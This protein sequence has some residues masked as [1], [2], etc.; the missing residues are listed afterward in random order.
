[1][2]KALSIILALIMALTMALPAFAA[3]AQTE[4][5]DKIKNFRFSDVSISYNLFDLFGMFFLDGV[6]EAF[7][8][9]PKNSKGNIHIDFV[10]EDSSPLSDVKATSDN[11]DIIKIEGYNENDNTI[12]FSTH[13][14]SG[15]AVVTVT[16]DGITKSIKLRVCN[17]FEQSII[18]FIGNFKY[19]FLSSFLNLTSF[20][21]G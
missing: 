7:K 19:H 11:E 18:D 14:K 17:D 5:D 20:I 21:F 10:P 1:M 8:L 12:W 2:K 3:D 16:A 15:K 6:Y 4:S 13:D 9:L